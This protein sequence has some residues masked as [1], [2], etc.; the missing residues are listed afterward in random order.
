MVVISNIIIMTVIIK[1]NDG[2][3]AQPAQQHRQPLRYSSFFVASETERQKH[4]AWFKEKISQPRPVEEIQEQSM[5]AFPS[6]GHKFP[7]FA[8]EME[9]ITWAHPGQQSSSWNK[10]D[11]RWAFRMDDE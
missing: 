7:L 4:I 1:F 10:P 8:F 3:A 6:D 2:A 5:P 9:E 11:P